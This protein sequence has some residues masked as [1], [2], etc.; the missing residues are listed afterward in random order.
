MLNSAT[1]WM[2]KNSVAANL[3]MFLFI[4]GGFML[5]N[6]VRQEVF[7]E[8]EVDTVSVQVIYQGASPSEVEQGI[9]LAVEDAVIDITGV[10]RITSQASEGSGS[11][12]IE[13]LP[14]TDKAGALLNIKNAV[15]A[16]RSFPELI[17][18]PIVSLQEIKR[19]VVSLVVYGEQEESHL[20][21][22][23]ETVR[24]ELQAKADITLVELSA[25]KP[26]EIS[27]EISQATLRAYNLTLADVAQIIRTSSLDRAGGSVKTRAGEVLIRT[28][29]RKNTAIEFAQIPIV[30]NVDGSF[31]RL[32][33]IAQLNDGFEEKDI[34][35]YFN[36]KPAIRMEIYSIDNET[37]KSISDS[38]KAYIDKKSLSLPAGTELAIFDDQ[39]EVFDA[40]MQMLIK[41]AAM[42]LVLVLIILSLFLDP[43]LAFWVMLGLPISILGSFLFF[44]GLGATL[45]MVSMFAFIITLGVVVDDALIVGESIHNERAKGLS[46][47]DA[48]IA[49][50]KAMSSPILFA[51]L[52]N[53]AAFMPL[54]FIPGMMGDMLSQIPAVVIAVLTVSLIESLLI[55]PAHMAHSTEN[56]GFW[57]QLARPQKSF[58]AWLHQFTEQRFSPIVKLAIAHRYSTLATGILIL[59][60]SIGLVRGGYIM[61]NLM[62]KIDSDTISVQAS[63]PYGTPMSESQ[64]VHDILVKS[65]QQTMEKFGGEDISK[66]IFSTIGATVSSSSVSS[67]SGSHEIGVIISLIDGEQ[68]DFSGVEFAN[69]WRELSGEIS[70]LEKIKFSGERGFGGKGEEIQIELT[71]QSDQVAQAAAK[72]LAE[73]L[74]EYDGVIDINDGFERGK[75][76]LDLALT[77]QARSLG[78][79][80]NELANQ[81]RNG[82]FGTEVLRQQRGRH[83]IKVMV[84]L[85]LIERSS[86]DTLANMTI[87]TVAGG[88]IPL[89]QAA[90]IKQGYAFTTIKRTQGSRVIPVTAGIDDNRANLSIVMTQ[91]EE[92]TLPAL[93]LEFPGL[94]Y[95]FEGQDNDRQES[96]SAMAQGMIGALLAIYGLLAIPFKSYFQPLIVMVSIPFGIVGAILGHMAMGFDLSLPSL[97]GIIALSGVVINDS[98]VLVVTANQYRDEEGLSAYQ[99][100]V[101]A[102]TR[103]LRPILLTT[104]TTFFGLMPMLMETSMQAR[105]L[106]PMAI[107][108]AFGLLFATLIIL[109]IV[110]SVYMVLE[111]IATKLRFTRVD[112][113]VTE[114]S[115]A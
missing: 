30:A 37:P 89:A 79:S 81:V 61:F 23:A 44:D 29:D 31:L 6:N 35:F 52:T 53:I 106:I 62:P 36:A 76:Q 91:L 60:L 64:R 87:H 59:M 80:S 105:F 33:D 22:L 75:T 95:S 32:G 93:Q 96:M 14:E 26:L 73:L 90:T 65:V 34:E 10:K 72:R 102:S 50:T 71:H 15:D 98:L 5:A 115:N 54:F 109:L 85:P 18:T 17:E 48:A 66:G 19:K 86:L 97:I 24:S 67:A 3:L 49:G 20:R 41:N 1:G 28:Q 78:I 88:E 39:S 107:S 99:A 82:F 25:V 104:L 2:T 45:N 74:A 11:V 101:K 55:L 58:S 100:A 112:S 43:K 4:V 114:I 70:G 12:S 77:P 57:K 84:R 16:I 21:E 27:I 7:P 47:L 51:V 111:D 13:L 9:L 103:R 46:N 94:F 110:P 92:Q 40:R 108:I 42:G 63:L 8:M 83:E 38:V 68:R 69:T 56:K 113:N